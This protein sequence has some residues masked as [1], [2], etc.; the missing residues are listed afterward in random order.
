MK[1]VR[2]LGKGKVEIVERAKPEAK[3]DW[4]VVQI[5]SSA[6]C[7]SE[8]GQY[9]NGAKYNFGHEACGEVVEVDS[10]SKVNVGDRVMLFAAA[11]CGSCP[12]CTSGRAIMCRNVQWQE[13]YHNEY[14]ALPERCLMPLPDNV[15]DD[16]G[17][18]LGD[19]MGTPYRAIKRLGVNGWH[20]VALFGLGPIGLSALLLCKWEGARVIAFE[21]HPARIK[22][23]GELGAD[24]VVDASRSDLVRAVMEYTE[25]EGAD[26]AMDC[27]GNADAESA[28]VACVG[29]GGKIAFVGENAGTIP[30]SP[31]EQ[32]IRKELTLI[33]SWYF[34]L[35][36]YPEMVKLVQS[37]FPLSR[38]ITHRYSLD[39]AQEAFDLFFS[40]QTGKVLF[41]F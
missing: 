38:L 33:G 19:A 2:M 35:D 36:D 7:G 17:A 34:A 41:E 5:R 11:F 20:T 15:P 9:L 30:V 8:R 37:G 12:E 23:G 13:G 4:A 28:A 10:P 16:V 32:F 39:D 29:R 26:I 27:T 22:L 24:V 1:S 3:D 25:G 6:I 14:A 31:S 18:L 40:G 21:K